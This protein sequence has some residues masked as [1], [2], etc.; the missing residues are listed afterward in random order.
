MPTDLTPRE[1][2]LRDGLVRA[3]EDLMLRADAESVRRIA[4]HVAEYGTDGDGGAIV[5]SVVADCLHIIVDNM[6]LV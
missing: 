6:G 3:L 4:E 5:D 1:H 2:E